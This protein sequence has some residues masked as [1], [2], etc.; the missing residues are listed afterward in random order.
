MIDCSQVTGKA[1]NKEYAYL[2]FEPMNVFARTFTQYV[3]VMNV[4][5]FVFCSGDDTYRIG[6]YIFEDL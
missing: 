6:F 4:F 5:V 2:R 3:C 1:L